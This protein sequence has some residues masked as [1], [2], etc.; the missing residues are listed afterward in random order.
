M[1]DERSVDDWY[2]EVIPPYNMRHHKQIIDA[3]F[4]DIVC[5]TKTLIVYDENQ[6]LQ[7]MCLPMAHLGR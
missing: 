3:E 4:E 2:W 7:D 5:R 6:N 1:T